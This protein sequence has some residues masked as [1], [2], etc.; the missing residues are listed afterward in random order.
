MPARIAVLAYFLTIAQAAEQ[1]E[2]HPIQVAQLA[3]AGVIRGS[4]LDDTGTFMIP[5]EEIARILKCGVTPS[6]DASR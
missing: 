3:Q 1:L 4:M 2:I 6:P 5:A